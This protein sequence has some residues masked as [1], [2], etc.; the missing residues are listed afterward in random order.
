MFKIIRKTFKW[1]II[2][3][4]SLIVFI[5]I[6]AIVNTYKFEDTIDLGDRTV[7]RYY[8]KIINTVLGVPYY[9]YPGV[10]TDSTERIDLSLEEWMNLKCN[11][12]DS[13]KSYD[14]TN[15]YFYGNHDLLPRGIANKEIDHLNCIGIR[16]VWEY[17]NKAEKDISGELCNNVF[18]CKT[19]N[20]VTHDYIL[21]HPKILQN[22]LKVIENP[23]KYIKQV[24]E[25]KDE[26]EKD[27]IDRLRGIFSCSTGKR[28][29]WFQSERIFTI[30]TIWSKEFY[31]PT[32]RP[33]LGRFIVRRKDL[34]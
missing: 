20:L 15:P 2:I 11:I 13:K 9:E 16:S 26:K 1:I 32:Q 7:P 23:C 24:G 22:A 14:T 3:G 18:T 19:I 21:A 12:L 29:P 31:I 5:N 27:N 8:P 17:G 34:K 6:W 28:Q 25:G 30:L 10:I 33:V 4:L